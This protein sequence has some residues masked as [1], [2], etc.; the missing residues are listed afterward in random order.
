MASQEGF[1]DDG[2]EEEVFARG[3]AEAD[4]IL[5]KASGGKGTDGSSLQSNLLNE[6]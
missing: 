1:E 4:E 2:D 6:M 3:E 5:R